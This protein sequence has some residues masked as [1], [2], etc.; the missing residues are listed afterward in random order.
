[1]KR[2]RSITALILGVVLAIP[3]VGYVRKTEMTFAD[4]YNGASWEKTVTESISY[5]YKDEETN[6]INGALPQYY[7][8]TGYTNTCANVAGAIVLG[9]YD[10]TYDNLIENFTSTRVYRD[11]IFYSAQTQA[12]QQTII[13]LYEDMETNTHEGG[14]TIDGF[15]NGLKKYVNRKGRNISYSQV[16]SNS[17]VGLSNI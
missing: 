8:T 5:A 3:S 7:S 9:F 6:S 13:Q 12:V 15:K 17:T 1:M 4:G 16:V 14:T 2:T 11:K 10:K